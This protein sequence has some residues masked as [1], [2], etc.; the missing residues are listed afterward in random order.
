MT[1]TY[2][3]P[4]SSTSVSQIAATRSGETRTAWSADVVEEHEGYWTVQDL[5]TGIFGSGP[6]LSAA[7]EDF[8]RALQE[9]FEVLSAQEALTPELNA[10][11][12][13][14]RQRLSD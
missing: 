4:P 5:E 13:Y 6:D 3:D 8:Q 11:L 10:Q 14:L 2:S 12:V 1:T 9:H 7:R